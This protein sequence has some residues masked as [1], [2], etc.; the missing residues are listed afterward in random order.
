LEVDLHGVQTTSGLIDS[1]I[2]KD[3]EFVVIGPG[4]S[5]CFDGTLAYISHKMA[6][7]HSVE[8]LWVVEPVWD[9]F[10]APTKRSKY[11]KDEV[12]GFGG[13]KQYL[14]DMSKLKRFGNV[15]FRQPDWCGEGVTIANLILP[16]Q[17]NPKR[18]IV[19]DKSTI[20]F[21]SRAAEQLKQQEGLRVL[22]R[23]I[24]GVRSILRSGD[25]FVMHIGDNHLTVNYQQYMS[26]DDIRRMLI[27]LGIRV[28]DELVLK[29]DS[30]SFAI[31][32]RRMEQHAGNLLG[33][34]YWQ[35]QRAGTAQPKVVYK[36]F[37]TAQTVL[38]GQTTV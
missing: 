38:I 11:S 6:V 19:Y 24:K 21:L 16:I 3:D 25:L 37:H 20:T 10:D 30:V 35:E 12:A 36:G 13:L 27:S 23:S 18:R 14:D 1:F 7:N 8:K 26:V 15:S 4:D 33:S 17:T 28:D 29:E 2:Q 32:G 34:N 22:E 31:N 9:D 5:V